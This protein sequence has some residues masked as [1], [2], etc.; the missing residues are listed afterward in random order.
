MGYLPAGLLLRCPGPSFLNCIPFPC[1]GDV[2]YSFCLEQPPSSLD[3]P[4]SSWQIPI[5]FLRISSSAASSINRLTIYNSHPHET[6]WGSPLKVLLGKHKWNSLSQPN[7]NVGLSLPP[8]GFTYVL[9]ASWAISPPL[10]CSIHREEGHGPWSQATS[11]TSQ[12][13]PLL[14]LSCGTL[15]KLRKRS[16]LQCPRLY[17]AGNDGVSLM[18]TWLRRKKLNNT[19]RILSTEPG[20]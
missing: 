4:F 15:V 19:C 6:L 17:N 5:C 16:R 3:H 13:C 11:F 8:V 9:I 18:I 10:E 20:T 1:L 7:R 14:M 2:L 12:L